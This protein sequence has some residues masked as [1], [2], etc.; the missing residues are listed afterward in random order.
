M[1]GL[2]EITKELNRKGIYAPKGNG[3]GKT[4]VHIILTNEVYA[5]TFVW[6]RNSKR[7]LEPVRVENVCLAIV[8]KETFSKV[9]DRLKERAPARIHPKRAA[10]R[11]LLSGLARCG[12]YWT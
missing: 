5:G 1:V 2:T 6:G 12:R 7:G 9:Q 8:D 4:G 11:F 3:W 10:S